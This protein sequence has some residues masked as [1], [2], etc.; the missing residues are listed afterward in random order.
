MDDRV[1]YAEMRSWLLGCYYEYCRGKIR[2]AE[3]WIDGE[4]EIGFAYNEF[5]DAF[6]LPVE[7]LMLE[8]LALILSGGRFPPG[9][10][11][12]RK[13][14][15]SLLTAYALDDL[16]SELSGDELHELRTDLQLLKLI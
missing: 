2:S 6:K 14:I 12:H 11:M 4:H 1:P 7:R 10:T 5:D 15:A 16:L 3:T 8:V 9:D 13:K